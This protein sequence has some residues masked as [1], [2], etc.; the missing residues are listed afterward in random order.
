MS[1]EKYLLFIG[2]DY[3]HM[4]IIRHNYCTQLFREQYKLIVMISKKYLIYI[5]VYVLPHTHTYGQAAGERIEARGMVEA[6]WGIL[7]GL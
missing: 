4:H 6:R 1:C 5:V 7:K 2:T 3:F